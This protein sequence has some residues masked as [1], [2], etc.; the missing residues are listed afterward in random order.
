M[1]I[2]QALSC[3]IA[4]FHVGLGMFVLLKNPASSVNKRFC[5]FVQVISVWIFFIFFTVSTTDPISATFRLRLVFCA[6]LFIPPS[7]FF[8]SSVYPDQ[9]ESS[10]SRYISLSFFCISIILASFSRFIVKA[11]SFEKELPKAEYGSLFP[12]HW[13]YFL[14]CMGYSLYVLYKKSKHLYG[15]KRLQLQ[16]VYVGAFA[17]IFTGTVT[18]F[19]LPI[20]GI[21]QVEVLVPLTIVPFPFAVAYAIAKYQLMDISMILRR[22]T[23]YATLSIVLVSIYFVVGF[24]LS[25]VLPVSEYRD[26]IERIIVTIIMVLTFVTTGESI[27]HLIDNTFFHTQYSYPEILSGSTT[28]FSS[29]HDLDELLRYGIKY[30]YDSIG[31]EKICI[32]VKD[33]K[34]KDYNL[35]SSINFVR[36]NNLFILNHDPV[37]AWLCQNRRALSRDQLGRFTLTETERYL[38][39]TMATLD[40]ESCIPVF[41]E[42][43]LFGIILLGK[44]IN[45][46]IFT[47]EDIQMF[48]AFSGQL[49]MVVK[50]AYL[51]SELK[52]AKT[53][54]E[55]IL[56]SLKNGV[57]V[58][59]NDD[60]VT[61][62]NNEAKTILGGSGTYPSETILNYIGAHNYQFLKRNLSKTKEV[63]STE[64]IIEEGNKKVPCEATATTL[65]TEKGERLGMLIILRDLTELKLLQAEKQRADRLAHLGIMA[66]NIAHEIKNPLV[67]I[68]TYFQLLPDK[69]NDAEFQ[70]DFQ[71]IALKEIERINRIV[72][73]MLNLAA[74]SKP[75]L[76]E[77]DPRYAII[78]AIDLLR[79]VAAE[80]GVE[81]SADLTKNKYLITANEDKLKQMLIN[82]LQNSIDA[83]SE[84]GH[85]KISTSVKD[86][87]SNFRMMAKERPCSIF[88][89]FAAPYERNLNKQYFIVKVSDNGLGI[90]AEKMQ[91]IF[92]PFFTDKEK[93]TGLGLAVVYNI[94]EEHQGSAYVESKEGYGTD[95]YICLPV[96]S[97][98]DNSSPK[99]LQQT[100]ETSTTV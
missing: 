14:T 90:P 62:V 46:K 51:Y 86:D 76:R 67:A 1:F 52:D 41:Q 87:I 31:I 74:P 49:A 40:V 25:R 43:D 68:N 89:S 100:V 97:E 29:I 56:Q 17:S 45:K 81:I 91:N 32:L 47:E 7:F 20:L 12:L 92:E 19:L 60:M 79:D 27:Q 84:K 44:K 42:S 77:M 37:V 96:Y 69:K 35:R 72:E 24:I 61:F 30:L 36:E 71:K 28:M 10:K 59:N 8:F 95:F 34:T 88:Y 39:S 21:W 23:I 73:D 98:H 66:A 70:N 26:T 4:L 9:R 5:V 85:I 65:K 55:N 54:R 99:P 83:I 22:T 15:I 78:D 38:E 94:L 57:I 18:N 3:F 58:T 64:I 33:E 11:V 82:I 53:Y 16:Y 93:G 80:K 63:F 75:N 50:N 2:N 48:L 13:F 6:A